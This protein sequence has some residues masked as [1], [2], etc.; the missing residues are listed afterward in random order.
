MQITHTERMRSKMERRRQS[1]HQGG[2]WAQMSACSTTMW[3]WWDAQQH[4]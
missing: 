2:V 4:Q 3:T 1:N